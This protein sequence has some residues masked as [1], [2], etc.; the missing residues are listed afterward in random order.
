MANDPLKP[1]PTLLCKLGSVLVHAEELT[2]PAGHIFDREAF[3]TAWDSEVQ[4]WMEEMRKL[5]FLPV[6]RS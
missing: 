2:S 1:S 6:K 5:A 4:A 3:L